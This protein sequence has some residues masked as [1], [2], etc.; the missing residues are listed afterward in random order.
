MMASILYG[1][2]SNALNNSVLKGVFSDDAKISMIK[3]IL[4]LNI[5]SS[6]KNFIS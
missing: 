3:M 4:R 5:D 6:K 2:W 1:P